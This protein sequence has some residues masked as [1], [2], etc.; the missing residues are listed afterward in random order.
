MKTIPLHKRAIPASTIVLGCMGLGGGWDQVPSGA[1][2][3]KQAREVL[4]AAVETGI[5]MFDHADIYRMGKAEK[6]F[7]EA[8]KERP[9]LRGDIILQSKCGI[10]FKDSDKVPGRYDFSAEHIEQSVDGSLQRLGVEYL[11][12]LLLHRPDPLVDPDEVAKALSRLHTSGKV[13]WF[14]VSNMNAGQMELLQTSLDLPLIVNQLEM[15]LLHTGFVETGVHVNQRAARGN[16]F[17]DG[18]MEYMQLSSVQIQAWSPLARGLYSMERSEIKE[19]MTSEG[20]SVDEIA[21][22]QQTATVVHELAEERGVSIEAIILAW[23]M[24][25]PAG[26]QPV[27]GTTNPQ[28]IR[29]CG[30]AAEVELTR[31]EWYR[32]YVASRG[33]PLP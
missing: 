22:V 8:L 2:H 15:S 6:V 30:Q 24:K 7:G 32:L 10:R 18:T 27:I 23:L 21:A 25:H 3:V 4:E 11:D 28:R 13:R 20:A 26:I 29:D 14:G 33:R 19:R 1:E 12:I 31:D 17:P 16:T 9:G 5:N